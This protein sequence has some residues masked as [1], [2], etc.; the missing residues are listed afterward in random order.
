MEFGT[1]HAILLQ[2]ALIPLTMSRG[3]IAAL[4]NSFVAR[5][6]PLNRTTR[7]HIHLGYVMIATVFAATIFFFTFFGVLCRRGEQAFCDKFRTEIMSTGYAIIGLLLIIG[8]TSYARH[9]IPYEIFYAVHHVVFLMYAVTIAHTLDIEQR[10]GRAE[11]SQTFQWFS[12]TLLFYL[13]DRAAMHINQKYTA[14]ITSQS[15]VIGSDGSRMILLK[16]RRPALFRFRSGQYAYLQVPMVD[17][18]W[19]PFSI[20]S[21][22][23]AAELEFYISVQDTRSWTGHLWDL[24]ESNTTY[25]GHAIRALNVTL[26][27]PCGTA[28]VAESSYSNV[29]AVGTGTGIVPLLSLFQDHSRQFLQLDPETHQ[30]EVSERANAQAE[31]EMAHEANQSSLVSR[32]CSAMGKRHGT[33]YEPLTEQVIVGDKVREA[34]RSR[35]SQRRKLDP[36]NPKR[37]RVNLKDMQEQSF[38]ATRSIY[39][40]V[41][42]STLPVW[43][44][45]LIGTT[46]SFNT[47]PA[48]VV[49]QMTAGLQV[50]TLLF[51]LC[52]STTALFLWDSNTMWTFIDLAV[53]VLNP[54]FDWFWYKVYES[55]GSLHQ[56]EVI[57]YCLVLGYMT[58]RCWW[59]TMQTKRNSDVSYIA[60]DLQRLDLVWVTRSAPTV[61]KIAPDIDRLWRHLESKWG[62]DARSVCR[63]RVYVTD[64]DKPACNAM[65][66]ELERTRILDF[67]RFGRPDLEKVVLDHNIDMIANQRSTHTLLA[68]VGSPDVSKIVQSCKLKVDRL[69]AVTGN[70]HRHSMDFVSE[71]YGHRSN[72][73][74]SS[75]DD[76]DDCNNTVHQSTL[77]QDASYDGGYCVTSSSSTHYSRD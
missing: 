2:M 34:I 24:L 58:L 29:L 18:Q 44:V 56:G 35:I 46:I 36:D 43:G 51:Q 67:I 11:R 59:R 21:G 72:W 33:Q 41:L 23:G 27:G 40:I 28:L 32:L 74:S 16:M 15:L 65:L 7:M 68:Y 76:D 55:N 69:T 13:C 4:G 64:Q 45:A 37:L 20:A 1:M 48:P 50:A 39:G 3:S 63:L 12:T 61:A 25:D 8:G 49:Y 10:S 30:I 5:F 9:W 6:I 17:N 22:T 31:I 75:D 38:A 42:L 57:K 26:L 71:F 53:S 70:N 47:T 14:R 19:H 66:Q 52:F 77:R 54:F 62:D 73:S 60:R